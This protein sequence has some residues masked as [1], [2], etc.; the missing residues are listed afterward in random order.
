MRSWV[1]LLNGLIAFGLPQAVVLAINHDGAE[2]RRLAHALTVYLAAMLPLAIGATVL[3]TASGV[4]D[5]PTTASTL[6]L[7]LGA[8]AVLAA[9]CNLWRGLYMASR[10]DWRF[11]VIS[12]LPGITLLA[13]TG[14]A[15]QWLGGST[16]QSIGSGGTPAADSL[17]WAVFGA[18]LLAAVAVTL[19]ADREVRSRNAARRG[20]IRWGRM[21][22]VGAQS[23]VQTLTIL[24][25]PLALYALARHQGAAPVDLGFVSTFVYVYLALVAPAELVA[26][27]LFSRWSRQ[28]AADALDQATTLLRRLL[29]LLAVA[30][31]PVM[32]G[33]YGLLP[34]VF[35][36][37]YEPIRAQMT[38]AGLAALVATIA[39]VCA[40]ALFAAGLPGRVTALWLLR[41]ALAIGLIALAGSALSADLLLRIGLAWLATEG[42]VAVC[43]VQMIRHEARQRRPSMTDPE[44]PAR[45]S[46][47]PGRSAIRC[48]PAPP[49]RLEEATRPMTLAVVTAAYP[50]GP[51]EDFVE[52]EF[53]EIAARGHHLIIVPRDSDAGLAS[54]LPAALAR[55]VELWTTPLIGVRT[56][57]SAL[58]LCLSSPCRFLCELP[59]LFA[60]GPRRAVRNLAVVPKAAWLA[61]RIARSR[62]E[63]IHVHWASTTGTLAMLAARWSTRPF[64]M[65]CHQ[66]DI[67]DDNLLSLKV[68]RA[69][70]SRFI[71][72]RGLAKAVALGADGA[73]C[74]VIPMAPGFLAEG[75]AAPPAPGS[76]FS[77]VTPA[78]L[79]EVKGHRYLIEAIGLLRARGL[80]IELTCFGAGPLLASL[81]ETAAASGA[82]DAIRFVGQIGHERLIEELLSGRF[83]AVCLPSIVADDGEY[84]GIPV[85][86]MEGMAAGLPVVS[87][88]TGSIPELVPDGAG[89]IVPDRDPLALATAIEQLACDPARYRQAA[90]DCFDVISNGWTAE[91][92]ADRLLAQIRQT[93]TPVGTTRTSRRSTLTALLGAGAAP[94]LPDN[95]NAARSGGAEPSASPDHGVRGGNGAHPVGQPP[96]ADVLLPRADYTR[97]RHRRYVSPTG[98]DRQ[99]GRSPTSAW[100]HLQPNIERIPPDCEVIFASG[101]HRFDLSVY[102]STAGP[103]ALPRDVTLRAAHYRKAV[104]RGP[105]DASSLKGSAGIAFLFLGPDVRTELWGFVLEDW[106][107]G[108]AGTILAEDD[109]SGLRIAGNLFRH[110]GST[111]FHHAVYLSGGQDSEQTQRDWT[112]EGNR[113]ELSPGSGAFLNIRGGPHGAHR[114]I[115]RYNEIV[116][117]GRWGI[118]QNDVRPT[119]QAS[120]IRVYGNRFR[121]R[122][123]QAVI[124][125]ADYNTPDHLNGVDSTFV[126]EHNWLENLDPDGYVLWRYPDIIAPHEPHRPTLRGNVYRSPSGRFAGNIDPGPQARLLSP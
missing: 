58:S 88:R 50:T 11:G 64:S 93:S 40:P 46:A 5:V 34:I 86:L 44:S 102:S 48:I 83:H 1:D 29:P 28:P 124:Q 121:A 38:L 110:N 27:N 19:L 72:Q 55:Q 37:A 112:I 4:I 56:L 75:P 18:T 125:F 123:N 25:F 101:D 41:L 98:D 118:V 68:K 70:F 76:R 96:D 31:V 74:L 2:P 23:V 95:A 36:P 43:A 24:L 78:S 85:S 16:A 100:R 21:V 89:L 71:S 13:T 45:L 104:L 63:H 22:R 108:G 15:L 115:I 49:F 120:S 62:V 79:L 3:A 97:R 26:P 35:G 39:R 91:R 82:Q 66:W 106:P 94:L 114:G 105:R 103:K 9:F 54:R 32:V 57:G 47:D 77:L 51:G 113:V 87:T 67:F 116:G 122:F 92:S 65:T 20:P 84:E 8:S 119:G 61:R 42:I 81:L 109:V 17:A 52:A 90:R 59:P 14:A 60:S 7:L 99:D 33:I 73:R 12:A 69:R 53:A 6:W 10:T 126:V 111:R 80:D 117:A 30:A 107:G